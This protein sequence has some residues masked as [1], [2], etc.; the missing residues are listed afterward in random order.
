MP[1]E[2]EG[3]DIKSEFRFSI[4]LA[5]IVLLL[6]PICQSDKLVFDEPRCAFQSM[7]GYELNK[8]RTP[9]V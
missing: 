8:H 7:I 1:R 3:D 9:L 2:Q 6:M 5:M 4:E